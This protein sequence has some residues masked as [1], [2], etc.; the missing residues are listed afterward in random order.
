MKEP[1][2]AELCAKDRQHHFHAY[3]NPVEFV[4]SQPV[5]ASLGEALRKLD[6]A[7]A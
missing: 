2:Y 6:R 3:L 5:M 4:T 1:N 7:P